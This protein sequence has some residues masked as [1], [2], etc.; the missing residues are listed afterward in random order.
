MRATNRANDTDLPETGF[1]D[2]PDTGDIGICWGWL[3]N[4]VD[5][6]GVNPPLTAA[7]PPEYE[8]SDQPYGSGDT[9]AFKRI[10][11]RVGR[12]EREI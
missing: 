2:R 10:R 3:Q 5:T 8:V 6:T 4:E 12:L 1:V 9:Y 11:L 7:N